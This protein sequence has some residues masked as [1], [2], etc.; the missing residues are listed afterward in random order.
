[1]NQFQGAAKERQ[2]ISIASALPAS[3]LATTNFVATTDLIFTFVVSTHK[4]GYSTAAGG[5]AEF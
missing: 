5:T 3:N 2:S 1:M 4:I